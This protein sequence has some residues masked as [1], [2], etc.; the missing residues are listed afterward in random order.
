MSLQADNDDD[1]FIM[2]LGS[3]PSESLDA[4]CNG[5]EKALNGPILE[6][7]IKDLPNDATMAFKAQFQLGDSPSPASMMVAS[8]LITDDRSTEEL[9]KRFGELLD[10]NVVLK[11][12]LKQNNDSMKE[13]FSLIA[14]CQEDMLRTH[15]IHKEKFDETKGLVEKLRQQNKE[16][17]ENIVHLTCTIESLTNGKVKSAPSSTVEF[18]TSPDD[19]TINKL[20]AQLELVEKQRRQVIVDNEKLTWQKESLEHIVDATTKERD[21]AKDKLKSLELLLSSKEHN[22]VEEIKLMH[23]T[24]DELRQKMKSLSTNM[25]GEEIQRRDANIKHLEA[26]VMSLQND[27]KTA[28]MK[29]LDSENVKLEFAQYKSGVSETVKSYK[30]QIQELST[31]LKEVQ[32]TVFQPVHMTM[33]C[34][35][36]TS[37]HY[38]GYLN[39]VK[40][41]D[42]T[43]KH[44]SEYLNTLTSGL[45]DTVVQAMAV[46]SSVQ[47]VKQER[48]SMDKVK[49]G[50]SE[51]KQMI[52]KQHSTVLS[53]I[54]Q[55]KST[56]TLFEGIFKDYNEVLKKTITKRE[57]T[58][59]NIE[60]LTA[61]LVARGEQIQALENQIAILSG[62]KED[63]ELLK[64]QVELYKSDFEAE[65]KSRAEMASEKESTATDLRVAQKKLQELTRQLEEVR[66]ASPSIYKTAVS[67]AQAGAATAASSS[68]TPNTTSVTTSGNMVYTCPKCMFQSEQYKVMEDHFDFCLDDF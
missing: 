59:P 49:A 62:Q 30:D 27:L 9:Q 68:T 64:A 66:K 20:T 31:R 32:T 47:D 33:S 41:Y 18:V 36:E 12:T 48:A 15:K 52:L 4:K 13:Q 8:T 39:N 6:D 25:N 3:S 2:I 1:S 29:I 54:A 42:R 16:L 40:L 50:L 57:D 19:D 21:D 63:C 55:L 14:S 28:Q 7:A 17:K 44:L 34:E 35:S 56:L 67:K 26:K 10:E 5:M 11:E 43:L 65:R 38:G 37:P 61:A 60:Q 53:N 51:I 58:P 23:G 22:H 24:I 46:L 45:T